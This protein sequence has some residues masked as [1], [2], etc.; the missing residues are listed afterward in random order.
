V[1]SV[2][3]VVLLKD[4]AGQPKGAAFVRYQM[5]QHAAAAISN[6]DGYFFPGSPRPISVAMA[7]NEAPAA[8]SMSM[9]P[10]GLGA[11]ASAGKRPREE[12]L[13]E[14]GTKLFVGQL[15]YS[16]SEVDLH[17]LFSPYGT[18]ADV[19]MLK[20]FQGKSKGAAF[21]RFAY[22]AQAQMAMTALNGYLFEGSPRPISVNIATNE[23]RR[24]LE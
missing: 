3:E 24:R 9:V 19:I 14:E 10:Y 20:D 17:S 23:K 5:P 16:R 1:G 22:P 13:H 15:P 21:V 11:G 6:L 4:K 12:Q 8:G 7:Q 2:S 18:V